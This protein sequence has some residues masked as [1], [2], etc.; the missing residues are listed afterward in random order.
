MVIGDR[1][2]P[3][4]PEAIAFLYLDI[5]YVYL[6][7]FDTWKVNYLFCSEFHLHPFCMAVQLDRETVG[8]KH[9][10]LDLAG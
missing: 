6:V 7:G 4:T 8:A 1:L 9:S 2:S 3:L 5:S 10:C